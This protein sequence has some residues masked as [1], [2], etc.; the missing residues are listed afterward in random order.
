MA[1]I[2]Y[3]DQS[4]AIDGRRIWIVGAAVPY[5]RVEAD[6][7]PQRIAAVAQ[8]G[9]NTILTACPWSLHEPRKGRFWF[10]ERGDV[11]RFVQLCGQVG[12]RVVIRAGPFVGDGYDAGG[13]P[14]W[15]TELPDIAVRQANPVYLERMGKFLRKL[16]GELADLQVTDGGPIL[17]VQ[18]EHAWHC[19]NPEQIDR[20]LNEITRILRESGI[21]VPILNANDLWTPLGGTIDTW[22]GW[23]EMLSHVRQLRVV[24]PD[25][26]RVVSEFDVTGPSVWGAEPPGEDR[27]P[28]QMLRYMAEILAAGGQPIVYP[29]HGGTN[30]AFL[31][32]QMPGTDAAPVTTSGALTA[33]LGEAGARTAGYRALKRLAMFAGHFGSVFAD[34]DPAYQPV[35]LDLGTAAAA[36][37]PARGAARSRGV[38]IVPQRGGQGRVVFVFAAGATRE[39]TLLLE[40]G[41]RMPISLGDQ[42]VGWYALD[43]DLQGQGRLDY[44]NLCPHALVGRSTLVLFGPEKSSVYLSIGG[45][46]LRETVPTG[47][48]PLVIPHKGITLVIC[49]T[50][51]RWRLAASGRRRS[52]DRTG[53]SQ[54][55]GS[56]RLAGPAPRPPAGA[57]GW[58]IG[59]QHRP[60]SR[61]AGNRSASPPS[62]VLARWPAAARP[63]DTAG[64]GCSS[65][66][67]PPASSSATCPSSPIAPTCTW[68]AGSSGWS[69]RGRV[70]RPAPSSCGSIGAPTCWW[71]WSTISA[72]RPVATTCCSTRGCTG[73]STRSRRCGRPSPGRSRASRR[74]RSSSTATFTAS[75]AASGRRPSRWPGR[76]PTPAGLPFSWTC[77]APRHRGPSS[78]TTS[79]W[80]TTPVTTARPS[81]GS[82]SIRPRVD[83]SGAGATCCDSP[84]TRTS[85]RR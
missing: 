63:P 35:T 75:R 14:G 79:R 18:N 1:T 42:P 83:R 40:N 34:L 73:T 51:R 56:R 44:A 85:P 49:N 72:V 20:Y 10:Q 15:L 57:I 43:V 69:A 64:T 62:P 65:R 55:A 21:G 50:G 48:K 23:D 17:A 37:A 47:R 71:P 5:A 53:R 59:R 28:T 74:I 68:M 30:F 58:A 33:P 70:P 84:R 24:Q 7:W 27:S 9:F 54:P 78:S 76:S 66:A 29:F 45:S 60:G 19:S 82:F 2:T 41:V 61:S 26:P 81:C 38:A 80:R 39:A 36:A 4:F 8:A 31:G 77:T 46:P 12:L 13:L 11:R 16:A 22:R 25:A 6:Q 52:S 67:P 3:N 32:G